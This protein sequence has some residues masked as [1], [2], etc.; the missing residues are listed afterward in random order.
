MHAVAN[1]LLNQKKINAILKTIFIYHIEHQ[2]HQFEKERKKVAPSST[3][4]TTVAPKQQKIGTDKSIYFS[5]RSSIRQSNIIATKTAPLAYVSK[6]RI[7]KMSGTVTYF[8]KK[9]PT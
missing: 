1:V 6:Q 9:K 7:I 3:F 4:S 5:V 2:Q 8:F